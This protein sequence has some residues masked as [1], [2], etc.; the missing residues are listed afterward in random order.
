METEEKYYRIGELSKLSNIPI[1]TLHYYDDIGL[2]KPAKVNELN[3]YRYYCHDQLL[4]INTI[5][6]FKMVGFSLEQIKKLL[7]RN[8]LAYSQEMIA[9]KSQEL[10]KEIYQ[11]TALKEKL[12]RYLSKMTK[13]EA[14]QT[15][16][17]DIH[18]REFPVMHVAYCRYVGPSNPEE[19][20][21]RFTK[22]TT[23]IERHD[24]QMAGTMMAIY[25]DDYQDY[26]YEGAD[27]EVCVKVH[28]NKEQEGVIRKLGGVLGA[29]A[30]HYGSY[31]TMNQT[32][33]KMLK[34]LER[35]NMVFTG[36][37]V[38]NYI[39]DCITTGS[40]EEYITEIILPVK[41]I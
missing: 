22:L 23:L 2:L 15:A 7:M 41:R 31:K 6:Y 20:Y 36:A 40:E 8:D 10:E 4:E 5:K 9:M 26:D 38:E 33:G 11:L 28:A 27:I 18:I 30:Y 29:V 12:N 35:N 19:F 34:W 21:L 17:L 37:A 39:V 1:R 13:T 24:L 25:H 32:Y 14:N 3:N 16:P